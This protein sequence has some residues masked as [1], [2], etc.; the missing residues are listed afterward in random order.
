MHENNGNIIFF[1]DQ[2]ERKISKAKKKM[3]SF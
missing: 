1:K 2:I 3:Q